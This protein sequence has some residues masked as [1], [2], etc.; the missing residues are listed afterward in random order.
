ML[1]HSR[2]NLAP[3]LA[4]LLAAAGLLLAPPPR[5]NGDELVALRILAV[6]DLHGAIDT[7]RVIGGRPV[8]GAAYLAAHL[9]RHGAGQPNVLLVGAGD[10]VG[11]SPPISA[12]LHEEPTMRA[13]NAMGFQLNTPGNHDFDRGTDEFLRLNQGGCHTDAACFEGAAFPSISANIV[14]AATGQTLLPP[15]RMYDVDGVPVA[16]IGAVMAQV[17]DTTVAGAVDGLLFLDPATAINRYVPELQAQGV[18]AMV[19][20]VHEGGFYDRATRELSGPI[21][22]T[23]DALDPDV[24]VVVSAHTHQGYVVRRNGKLVTQAYSNGTAFADIDLRLDPATGEVVNSAAGL[25]TTYNDEV[26]PDPAVQAIVDDAAQQVAPVVNRVVGSAAAPVTRSANRAGESGLGD[27]VADAFREVAGAQIGMTNPGGLRDDLPAGQ[28]TWG[29]LFQ[30]QPF[31]NQVVALTVTGEQLD[32]LFNAQWSIEAGDTERYRPTQVSGLQV[33]WDSR[34]PLGDRIVSLTLP[35]GDPVD[36]AARYRVAVNSFMA[37]GGEGYDVL[38]AAT[39]ATVVGVDLDVLVAY[40][41]QL[42]QPFMRRPE[43]RI[44]RQG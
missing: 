7:G 23:V 12:L 22:A 36:P 18:H 21:T 28:L 42:P 24:D 37:G 26:D 25:V 41:A 9:Q 29:D 13:L 34:R 40:V 5:V 16:F 30:A 19:V 35:G 6:N 39:D 38:L 2:L 1:A 11:G 4:I 44:V 33:T 27:L 8:G 20:L 3:L 10:L 17:P 14:V 31:G 32:T 43:G 15:Y